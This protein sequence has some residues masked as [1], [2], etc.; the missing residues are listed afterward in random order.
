MVR[1]LID[2]KGCFEQNLLSRITPSIGLARKSIRQA[3]SFLKDAEDLIKIGKDRMAVI[4]LYN[5]FFHAARALLFKDGVKE[6]SHFCVARYLEEYYVKRELIDIKF[7][8]YVDSLR[9]LRHDIQYSVEEAE[10]EEDLGEVHAVC[11]S[12]IEAVERALR[13]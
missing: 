13:H 8:N 10:I 9:D 2:V 7:L 11:L 3:R 1:Y 6:R 12:F 4:A 5:A